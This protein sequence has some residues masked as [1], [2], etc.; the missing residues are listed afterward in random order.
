MRK[1]LAQREQLSNHLFRRHLADLDLRDPFFESLRNEYDGFDEWVGSHPG[2]RCFVQMDGDDRSLL[3]LLVLKGESGQIEGVSPCLKGEVVLKICTFKIEAHRT[4]L[5]NRFMQLALHEALS[6]GARFCYVTTFLHHEGLI[7]LLR[8][9]GFERWGTVDSS[10]EVV[11]VKDFWKVHGDALRDYPRFSMKGRSVYWLGIKRRY[12]S[13]MFPDSILATEGA[14]LVG[15]LRHTNAVHK[16]YVGRMV[17]MKKLEVGDVLLIYCTKDGHPSPAHYA[18]C[19]TS[20]CVVEDVRPALSFPSLEELY[21]YASP[22]NLFSLEELQR[23]YDKNRVVV[24]MVYNAALRRK[25][26]LGEAREVFHEQPNYLGC[27]K[28]DEQEARELLKRG[29]LDESFII[30]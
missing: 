14:E 10:D 30:D 20:V 23:F 13:E 27:F 9:F 29:N 7:A 18:G 24:K 1:C 6:M 4:K 19:L 11:F 17:D 28:M 3:G 21:A 5:G 8:Q 2:R 16:V 25:P 12:H 26:T 22:Y 15:D